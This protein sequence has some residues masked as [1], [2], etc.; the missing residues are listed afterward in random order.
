MGTR[1]NGVNLSAGTSVTIST[2]TPQPLGVAAAGS[3]GE[4]S[5]AG[6]VHA[7][8]TGFASGATTAED[9]T[10][11]G[12][13]TIPEAGVTA[14]WGGGALTLSADAG[15]STFASAN[16]DT[17]RL[18]ASASQWDICT[19]VDVTAGDGAVAAQFQVGFW[20]SPTSYA[21]ISY[22]TDNR[23][24]HLF[25]NGAGGFANYGA[26]SGPSS[27]EATGGQLWLRVTR[28]ADATIAAWWG[29]GVGGA[30]PTA[31]TRTH[32]TDRTDLSSGPGTAV[33]SYVGFGWFGLGPLS[34]PA[35]VDVLA[36]RSTWQGS[37]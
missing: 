3:T 10:G 37:L 22:R 29:V 24:I 25:M 8:P 5:D 19:R 30:L 16:S 2:A 26:V 31:W 6:H 34:A 20:S 21:V 28:F 11:T 18:G 17:S 4:A 15:T 12:W 35:S 14:A 23:V 1:V 36:I 32:L 27:G 13:T 9:M 33:R 7:L